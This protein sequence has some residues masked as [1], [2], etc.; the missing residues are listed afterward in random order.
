MSNYRI[1]V[2]FDGTGFSGWQ[3]QSGR[4]N[5]IQGQLENALKIV[6][7]H[8]VK[9]IGAGR[10][11]AGVHALNQT[12][13]FFSSINFDSIR[14]LN[15]V[16]S[17]IPRS[18]TV[19][20]ISGVG[21]SFHARYSAKARE[22]EYRITLKRI[23]VGRMYYHHVKYPLN[24]KLMTVA[25]EMFKGEHSF[26]SICKNKSDKH[27]FKCNVSKLEIKL[28]RTGQML[29]FRIKANR[30]LH[31]M[32]R[33]LTGTIIDI[34]RG[35]LDLDDVKNKLRNGEKIKATYLPPDGLFLKKIYY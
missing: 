30:F 14:L 27:D 32:V 17:L 22:Y 2:E 25:A 28:N 5:T 7:K 12:A 18:I 1:I 33:G 15:S 31:S 16:N 20:N 9:L 19:K 8:E 21:D 35:K 23:S 6:L 11:D 10:T 3:N 24:F 13:N 29:V 4:N 26:K 34:G